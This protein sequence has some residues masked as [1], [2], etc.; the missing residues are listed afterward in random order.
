ML[1]L[2]LL[3]LLYAVKQRENKLQAMKTNEMKKT[4]AKWN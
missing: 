4:K 1:L 2:L 3:L